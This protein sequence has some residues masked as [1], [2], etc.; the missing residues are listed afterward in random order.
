MRMY[1]DMQNRQNA[2]ALFSKLSEMSNEIDALVKFSEQPIDPARE[3][4]K[5]ASNRGEYFR[6]WWILDR[7]S[8]HISRELQI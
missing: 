3:V 2:R 1:H 6:I 5:G 8:Y 4:A 7:R